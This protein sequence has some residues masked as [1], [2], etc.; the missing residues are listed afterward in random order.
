MNTLLHA[1]ASLAIVLGLYLASGSGPPATSRRLLASAFLTIAALNL[2]TTLQF[3]VPAQPLLLLRP[4]LAVAL[5][6]LLYLHVAV[7]GRPGQG[8]RPSDVLHI[9]GPCVAIAL[10][11]MPNM[12]G[13]LDVTIVLMNLFYLGLIGWVSRSTAGTMAHLGRKLTRLLDPWR[14]LVMLFLVT[15]IMID[16]LIIYAYGIDGGVALSRWVFG[17]AGLLLTLG[18]TYLLLTG[19]HRRGPLAWVS[20]AN[21]PYDPEADQLIERLESELLLG[22]MYLDPNLTLHR[23]ARRVGLPMRD[24]ST[25]INEC[26]NSNYNQ[27]LNSFRIREAERILRAEPH[28]SMTDVMLASGFQNKSTFNAAFRSVNGGSPTEWR[29]KQPSDTGSAHSG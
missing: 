3:N 29:K 1:S 17:L 16:L 20:S 10:R 18:F 9:I 24:V 11:Q 4:G 26:R 25:A 6:A 5:P 23:F 7:A 19:M 28:R 27:W 15:V 12:S 14:R 21:R 8:L 22:N 2:L 13:L